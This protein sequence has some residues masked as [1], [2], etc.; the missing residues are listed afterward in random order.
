MLITSLIEKKVFHKFKLFG[1]YYSIAVD[2][3]GVYTF[4]AQVFKEST[5]K[6]YISFCLDKEGY[7]QTGE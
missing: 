2:A 4:K 6:E 5:K 1:R 7:I 3:T